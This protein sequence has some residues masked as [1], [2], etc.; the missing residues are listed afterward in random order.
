MKHLYVTA[1]IA[2]FL[3][4]PL[5][6]DTAFAQDA[7]PETEAVPEEPTP[8]IQNAGDTEL[9]EFKWAA[10]VLVVFADSPLDPSYSDQIA[11]LEDRPDALLERDVVVL[12]DTDPAARSPIRTALR[13]RGFALVVVDKDGR[14]MLRKPAPWNVREITRAI[15]KTPLRQQELESGR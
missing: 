6:P 3:T 15:D 12:T 13:P 10:R 7:L 5:A 11:L 2:L 8:L 1:L 14:V 9:S 4:S